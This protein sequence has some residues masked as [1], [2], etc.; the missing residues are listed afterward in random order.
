MS[1]HPRG[2]STTPLS[3]APMSPSAIPD[4]AILPAPV[5]ANTLPVGQ[6][7]TKSAKL[8]PTTLEDR[9]YDDVGTR[10]YKDVILISSE[11]GQFTTSLGAAHLINNRELQAGSEVGTIEAEQMRVRMLKDEGASLKK[12]FQDKQAAEWVKAQ[13]QSG[14]EVGFVTAAREVTNASYKRAR[15]V[16]IGNGNWEVI[17]EVGGEGQDGKRRDSGLEVH[18]GSKSDVVGVIVKKVQLTGDQVELGEELSTQF[19]A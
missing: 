13:V 19:W 14:E 16:D 11:N 3:T 1:R 12:A 5:A 6:L 17:R 10:W 7:V 9:D 15:L 8:D 18:T 4:L 2:S